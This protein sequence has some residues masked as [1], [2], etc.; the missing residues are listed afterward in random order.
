MCA[1]PV[2]LWKETGAVTWNK[3]VFL[4]EVRAY[5][6]HFLESNMVFLEDG[7]TKNVA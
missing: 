1:L 3:S 5:I 6:F 7:V 2:G 4:R